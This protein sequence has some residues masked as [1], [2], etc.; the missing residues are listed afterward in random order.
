MG[1]IRKNIKK[2]KFYDRLRNLEIKFIRKSLEDSYTVTEA[3]ERV[4]LHRTTLVQK[5][6]YFSIKLKRERGSKLQVTSL[7]L[8][9]IIFGC[10]PSVIDEFKPSPTPTVI[11]IV[12]PVGASVGVVF[13]P[14]PGYATKAEIELLA[15]A[16]IKANEVKSSICTFNFLSKRK[17]IQTNGLSNLQVAQVIKDL[18]GEVPVQFYYSR[19]TSAR[20]YRSP[21]GKTIYLNRKFITPDSDLCDVSGTILHESLHAL[22]DFEHDFQWSASREFS[23][24]YSSDH[25]FASESY[26]MSDSGGCCQ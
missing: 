11:P 12:S 9:I 20:A 5:L 19:F 13:K 10:K 6:K 8:L 26:S 24:P 2:S 4:G 22:K 16:S 21:P 7:L 25:A 18:S 15:R 17:M 14:V 3:A 1:Q 23:V